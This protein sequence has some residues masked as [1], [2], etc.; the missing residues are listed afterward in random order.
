MYTNISYETLRPGEIFSTTRLCKWITQ[1]KTEYRRSFDAITMVRNR[2]G[3][4]NYEVAESEGV[5]ITIK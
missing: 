2:W 4:H 1:P 5:G 3:K